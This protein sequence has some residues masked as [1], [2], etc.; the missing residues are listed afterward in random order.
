MVLLVYKPLEN[1][2]HCDLILYLMVKNNIFYHQIKKTLLM[3]LN[4]FQQYISSPN[5]PI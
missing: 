1:I 2:N 4:L 5:T 3:K